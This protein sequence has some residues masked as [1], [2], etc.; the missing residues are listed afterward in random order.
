MAV[1]YPILCKEE[2]RGDLPSSLISIFSIK[3]TSM[4]NEIAY[5]SEGMGRPKLHRDEASNDE[6]SH[7]I[8]PSI[9]ITIL[10]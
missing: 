6:F 7:T 1:A 2:E 9:T 3:M 8:C 10:I 4:G 5:I